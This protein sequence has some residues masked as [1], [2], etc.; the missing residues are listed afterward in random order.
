MDSEYSFDGIPDKLTK[1]LEVRDNHRLFRRRAVLTLVNSNWELMCCVVEGFLS[2]NASDAR[3]SSKQYPQAILYEDLL[4]GTE[5]SRFAKELQ[6]GKCRLGDIHLERVQPV[7]WQTQHLAVDNTYMRNAGCVVSVCDTSYTIS[8]PSSGKIQ[9]KS[10]TR[11]CDAEDC[12]R[13][14]EGNGAFSAAAASGC[15]K[16]S[17][18]REN[19]SPA[20]A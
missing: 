15:S 7:Q 6:E 2:G 12:R 19:D 20:R 5:C 3:I 13:R 10:R 14:N 9:P 8:H 11:E 4:T 18:R 1:Y 17:Q 16:A